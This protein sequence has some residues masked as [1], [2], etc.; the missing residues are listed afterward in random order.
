LAECII[1]AKAQTVQK[2]NIQKFST[3]TKYGAGADRKRRP[4]SR[5]VFRCGRPHFLVQTH[6]I[7]FSKFMMCRYG[8]GGL[9]QCG[10]LAD[11]RGG[12]NILAI[13]CR[14]PLWTAP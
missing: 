2:Q 4:Q 7:F 1:S 10:H 5:G 14:R 13:L 6:R 11:K 9:S 8:Q 12:V 3:I